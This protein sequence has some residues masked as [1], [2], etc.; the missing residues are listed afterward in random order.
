LNT[1][2]PTANVEYLYLQALKT[3]FNSKEELKIAKNNLK[4]NLNFKF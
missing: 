2:T 4:N 3:F 1:Y